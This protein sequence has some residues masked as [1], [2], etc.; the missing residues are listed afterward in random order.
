MQTSLFLFLVL[1]AVAFVAL[2]DL[3]HRR[4]CRSFRSTKLM[5]SR[6]Y[7][8]YVAVGEIIDFCL[9]LY[10]IYITATGAAHFD[11]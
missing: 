7:A 9:W 5:L 6:L 10:V 11:P 3:Y 4:G 2:R 1:Q 8:I